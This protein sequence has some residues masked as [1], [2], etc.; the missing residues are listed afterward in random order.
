MRALRWIALAAIAIGL[1]GLA[2]AA[3]VTFDVLDP[4]GFGAIVTLEDGEVPGTVNIDIES[5]GPLE[6]GGLVGDILAIYLVGD[7]PPLG[8]GLTAT[9]EDVE[10]V[11]SL[12]GGPNLLVNIGPSSIFSLND[13]HQTSL[14]LASEILSVA[15]LE[16][17]SLQV[18]LGFDSANIYAPDGIPFNDDLIVIKPEAKIPV[19]PEPGT[20]AM[21]LLGLMGLAASARRMEAPERS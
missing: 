20:A 13:I 7:E 17:A 1:P 21:M 6:A 12:P 14:V 10:E 8:G 18:W 9:G 3:S 19:I 4:S 16:G 11:S 2:S 15:A 5:V